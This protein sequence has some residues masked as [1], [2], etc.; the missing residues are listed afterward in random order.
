MSSTAEDYVLARIAETP[1]TRLP[2]PHFYLEGVFPD[3]YY[4]ELRANMPDDENYTCLGDTGRVP[5]GSYRERFVFLPREDDIA[6]LP[7]A[8]RAFWQDLATWLY[9]QNLFHAMV[10][11]FADAAAARFAGQMNDIKLTSEVLVVRDRTHYAIGPHTDAPHRFMSMLFYCPPDFSQEHLGT[12]IYM[13]IDRTFKCAGGPHH[14]FDKFIKVRTLP[15]RPNSLFGFLK[16]DLSFHGVEPIEDVDIARDVILYDIRVTNP[17][18]L[19][20]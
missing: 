5:K 1:V 12:S 14:E 16:T 3:D 7:E 19:A 9:G 10:A 17:G 8:K 6:A 13:P 2:S 4:Q 11:K 15:F 18:M 20:A